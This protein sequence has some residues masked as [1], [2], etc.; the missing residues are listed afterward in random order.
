MNDIQVNQV[1]IGTDGELAFAILFR[2]P[3]L[4]VLCR[5]ASPR[6]SDGKQ[7]FQT[8]SWQLAHR[9]NA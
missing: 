2:L 7:S 3:G 6:S 9:T 1:T 8:S 4:N 5:H